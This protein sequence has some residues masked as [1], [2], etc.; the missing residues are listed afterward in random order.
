MRKDMILN[1]KSLGIVMVESYLSSEGVQIASLVTD[2]KGV[3]LDLTESQIDEIFNLINS[4]NAF[5][6]NP[7]INEVV[8]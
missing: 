7:D 8:L 2:S 3:E 4:N 1:I 5:E 6:L